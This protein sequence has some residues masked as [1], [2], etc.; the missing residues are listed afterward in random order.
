MEDQSLESTFFIQE[1]NHNY[2][3]AF[4]LQKVYRILAHEESSPSIQFLLNKSGMLYLL[5]IEKKFWTQLYTM[6]I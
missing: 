4:K 2:V 6:Q 1:E 5:N 3:P